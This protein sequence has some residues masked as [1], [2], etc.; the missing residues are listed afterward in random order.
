MDPALCAVR[1]LGREFTLSSDSPRGLSLEHIFG[2][3]TVLYQALWNLLLLKGSM[4]ERGW[5]M[6]PA[7]LV[8]RGGAVL[9]IPSENLW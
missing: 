1:L 3:R 6:G 5:G 8:P 7:A 2:E 9:A 4:G